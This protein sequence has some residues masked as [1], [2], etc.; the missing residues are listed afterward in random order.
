[1]V[2]CRRTHRLSVW[3]VG[4]AWAMAEGATLGASAKSGIWGGVDAPITAEEVPSAVM[5]KQ[6][7]IVL[8]RRKERQCLPLPAGDCGM[9]V[10][11]SMQFS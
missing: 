6:R 3:G 7:T 10:V 11:G 5:K 9:G 8:E 4:S 1:M 2:R